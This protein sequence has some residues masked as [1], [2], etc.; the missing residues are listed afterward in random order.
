MASVRWPPPSPGD[1]LWCHFP[2]V[3]GNPGPKPRPALVLAVDDTD[4][5]NIR[6]EV[7]Y[8]TSKKTNRL[9]PGEFLISKQNNANAYSLAGLSYDTKFDLN[10]ATRLPY[11]STWFAVAPRPPGQTPHLGTLHPS[12]MP[13]LS[14]AYSAVKQR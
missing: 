1:I 5:S 6:V 12:L 14:A 9:Y 4:S 2:Q 10:Q 11:N 3:P 13:A 8:G 7:V